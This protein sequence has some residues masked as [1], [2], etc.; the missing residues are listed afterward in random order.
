MSSNLRRPESADVQQ[1]YR[2]DQKSTPISLDTCALG[3]ARKLGVDAD[4]LSQYRRP[5]KER[6]D[7]ANPQSCAPAQMLRRAAVLSFE[8]GNPLRPALAFKAARPIRKN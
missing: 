2:L 5:G 1:S 7:T 3:S 4:Q 6:C 8:G